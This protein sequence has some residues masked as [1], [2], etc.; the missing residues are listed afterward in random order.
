VAEAAVVDALAEESTIDSARAAKASSMSATVGSRYRGRKTR[1]GRIVLQCADGCGELVLEEWELQQLLRVLPQE[2][3]LAIRPGSTPPGPRRRA[4]RRHRT[5]FR[6]PGA[7]ILRPLLR[8]RRLHRKPRVK[9]LILL[10]VDGVLNA[11]CD[12]GEHE[13]VWPEWRRGH[14]ASD[15]TSWPILWTPAVVSR[16]NSWHDA[17]RVEIQ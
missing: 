13:V 8:A 17:G 5:R 11:L 6:S 15:D 10:D 1:G 12:F 9:P 16:L 14:A 2:L 4:Q 3:T 7:G